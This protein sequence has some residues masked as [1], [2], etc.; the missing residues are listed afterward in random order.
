MRAQAQVKHPECI[1]TIFLP[2]NEETPLMSREKFLVPRNLTGYEI[3]RIARMRLELQSG[4][5]IFLLCGNRMLSHTTAA[6]E[7]QHAH[8]DSSDG[9]LYITYTLENAFGEGM[10]GGGV[11]RV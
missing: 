7:L 8:R 1:P 3:Y 2:G 5:A 4:Q 10:G 11:C 6:Y 9:F